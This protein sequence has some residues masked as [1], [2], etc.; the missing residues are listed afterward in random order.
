MLAAL[1]VLW[2]ALVS[3]YDEA[4]LLIRA[5]VVWFVGTIP[6][7]LLI[8]ALSWLFVPPTEPDSPPLVWP[9]LLAAFAVLILPSPFAIGLYGLAAVIVTGD[10]PD[11]RVFW[12][13][14]RRWWRR[15]LAMFAISALVLVALVFNT[16]FYVSVTEGWLQAVSVLWLYAILFWITLQVYLIPL[17]IASEEP[18]PSDA[19]GR[20]DDERGEQ[21]PGA[22][23][24]L[25]LRG[26]YRRA[27]ILTLANP[28][29]SLL[30]LAGA[31]LSALLSTLVPPIYPLVAMAYV[32]LIGARGLRHLRDKYLPP[33]PEE[34][35]E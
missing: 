26:L 19:R 15:G 14:L 25:S 29:F 34:A 7:F 33:D 8:L 11:F 18:E 16:W 3:F 9:L 20:G 21:E 17:L 1:R 28:M 22:G 6:F 5:N 24:P 30:L 4:L 31:V 2:R 13:S 10:T 12:T 27:A 35:V 23:P 32:A